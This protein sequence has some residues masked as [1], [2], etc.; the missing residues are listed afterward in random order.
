MVATLIFVLQG[1]IT[2]MPRIGQ[3]G[4]EPLCSGAAAFCPGKF[5]CI[6]ATPRSLAVIYVLGQCSSSAKHQEDL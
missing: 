6:V 1:A 5:G 4:Q 3:T 2:P